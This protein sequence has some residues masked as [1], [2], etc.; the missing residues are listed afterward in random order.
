MAKKP[1]PGRCVHCR[2]KV[3]HLT[4]DHVFPQGWYPEN[5]LPNLEKWKVPACSPCNWKYGRIEEELGIRIALC[6]ER[7]APNAKGICEKALR[8]IDPS[9]G[10]NP[11]DRAKRRKKREKILRSVLRGHEIPNAVYPGFEERWNRPKSQQVGIPVRVDH[12]KQLVEKVVKGITYI[13]DR[14]YLNED[15]QI[16][17][18][19][20]EPGIAVP[21]ERAVRLHGEIHSREPGIEVARAVTPDDGVSALY[22]ITIWGEF[23]LYA[24]VEKGLESDASVD[25]SPASCH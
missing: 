13:E 10:R 4:W 20:V 2:A 3:K 8:A 15:T 24:T 25:S 16:Q 18:H 17:H 22:K 6:L 11:T 7:D 5:T 23:V 9:H 21:L 14:V 19:V 12:L 1:Q